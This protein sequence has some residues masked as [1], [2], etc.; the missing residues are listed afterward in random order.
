MALTLV[1]TYP[2]VRQFTAAIPGDAFDGWQ[3]YWNLWWVREALLE[4]HSQPYFTNLL[5]HPTGV[6]LLFHTLNPFNGLIALP[7][8]LAWGLLPAYNSIVLLSFALGGLGGYLLC[9]QAL[10]ARGHRLFAFVG[11]AIFTYSPFHMAHL[12][13]HMQVI[14]LEWIP[15]YRGLSAASGAARSRAAVWG[16]MRAWPP[17]FSCWWR[18]ATGITYSTARLLTGVVVAWALWRAL[19]AGSDCVNGATNRGLFVGDWRVGGVCIGP[20]P[21]S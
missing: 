13:G 4:Q 17:S 2:L 19:R 8:Q 6:G 9:R 11:G 20:Q 16:V 14:S 12:L 5:F 15:F 1:L 3:N 7:V 18:C 21:A 10:G